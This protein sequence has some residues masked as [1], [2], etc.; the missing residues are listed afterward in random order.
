M[1][2][3]CLD[4][5]ITF[6]LLDDPICS[7]CDDIIVLALHVDYRINL[8]REEQNGNSSNNNQNITP[9]PRTHHYQIVAFFPRE[10]IRIEVFLQY[11]TAHPVLR[12][13]CVN[14]YTLDQICNIVNM[15]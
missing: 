3:D 6:K 8:Q 11:C 1:F 9:H 14:N 4:V 5:D 2:L 10:V 13:W 7:F 12:I 15:A